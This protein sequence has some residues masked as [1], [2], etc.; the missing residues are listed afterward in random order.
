M[1]NYLNRKGF[2]TSIDCSC[3][4]L[5]MLQ[6]GLSQICLRTFGPPLTEPI[7]LSR[8]GYEVRRLKMRKSACL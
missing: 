3:S 7:G 8:G 1:N 5:G 2:D 6:A 4:G